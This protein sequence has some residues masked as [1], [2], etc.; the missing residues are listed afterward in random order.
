[1]TIVDA[2][3][4][5]LKT[6]AERNRD[7]SRTRSNPNRVL[8]LHNEEGGAAKPAGGSREGGEGGEGTSHVHPLHFRALR[9]LRES[10]LG[11]AGAG[12]GTGKLSNVRP[13][14]RCRTKPG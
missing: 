3:T 2:S 9:S 8:R 11:L 13:S 6:I 12:N 1:M 5:A 7:I 14:L 4:P 10:P